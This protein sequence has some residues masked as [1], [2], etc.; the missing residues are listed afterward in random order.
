MSNPDG[1]ALDAIDYA[2]EM[3][4]D[5]DGMIFLCDW[6]VGIAQSYWPDYYKWLADRE[7]D[8]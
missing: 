7:L 5:E 6:R 2:I 3:L 4:E 8:S 1:E